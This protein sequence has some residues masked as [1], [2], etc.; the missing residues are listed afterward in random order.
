LLRSN[1]ERATNMTMKTYSGSC[2]CGAVRFQADLDLS[3]GLTKCNCSV[4][5]KARAWFAIVPPS[6]VRLV[7]E[8]EAQAIYEWVPPGRPGS[9]LHFQFC[10]RCGIRTFGRGDHGPGGGPFCFVNVA[11]LDDVDANELAAAPT[12]VVD[13]RNGRYDRPPQDA[14]PL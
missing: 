13:G 1:R 9:N 7:A 10:K 6:R 11:A 8:D 4:C 12:R 5:T 3:E 2:H 14:R